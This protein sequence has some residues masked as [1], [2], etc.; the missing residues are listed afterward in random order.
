[1][2]ALLDGVGAIPPSLLLALVFVLPALEASVFLGIVV[3]GETIV[4]VGGVA[5]RAGHLSLAAVIVAAVLGAVVG[6][7]V[8]YAVGR[9]YGR[10]LLDRWASTSRRRRRADQALAL[11]RRRG[12]SAVAFGRWVAGLRTLVPGVAG[13]SGV[14][15]STFTAANALGGAAWAAT[16]AVAGYLA[17]ASYRVLES[18]LGAAGD[19]LAGVIVV[20]VIGWWLSL[21]FAHRS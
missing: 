10:R 5:A 15:R 16:V 21:R 11:L 18:R 13:M 2:T 6:D 12:V 3:P 19:V 17:G 7:Q 14:P 1:M 9:R 4:L 8:G 20:A